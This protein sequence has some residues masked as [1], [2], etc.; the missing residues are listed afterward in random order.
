MNPTPLNEQFIPRC[1]KCLL[2]PSIKLIYENNE[3]K[4][5]YEC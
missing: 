1:P 5:K 2:I 4:I 3:S